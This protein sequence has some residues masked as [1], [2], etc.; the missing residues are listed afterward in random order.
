MNK[1][2]IVSWSVLALI[3]S[4]GHGPIG[5]SQASQGTPA[6]APIRAYCI[7][8]NW[9]PGGPN[10]YPQPGHWAEADPQAHVAWYK[11]I[12]CNVIQTFCVSCNGYAWYKGGVVPEQP[13][14]KHDFL[15][16]VVRLGHREKMLV[17]GY[18][19]IGSNT[20][21]GRQHPELSY[22]SPSACHIPYTREYL[23]YLAAAIRDAV[24]KT[25]IDGFMIDWVWMPD[26]GAN[27]GK[28]LPCEQKLYR[29]LMGEEF[30]GEGRLSKQQDTAYSRKAIDRCWATIRKAA[31]EANPN[32]IIWLSCFDPTHPHVVDSRMFKEVDWLMNEGGDLQRIRSIR[33]MIG[34]HTRLIT[35]LADW[36]KQDPE[37]IVPEALKAGIGLYGFTKPQEDSLLPPLDTYL[38]QPPGQLKGDAKNIVVLARA[39]RAA[40]VQG[41]TETSTARKPALSA[42][43]LAGK[44]IMVLGDSITQGGSYV[45]F[46]EYYLDKRYPDEKFDLVSIGLASETLSG[47]SEPG[48]PFP[49]PCVHER[50]ERALAKVKPQVLIACYGMNDGIYHPQ[51]AERMKA[52]QDGVLRMIR[53]AREHGVQRVVLL[54]PPVFDVTAYVQVMKDGDEWHYFRPYVRYDDV[55][56][57]YA[58]WIM[59]LRMDGVT[60]VD[61]HAEMSA[62]LAERR[63]A[64]PN[65]RLAGDGIHPGDLGHLIMAQAVL[66]GL[67]EKLPDSKPEDELQASLDDPLYAVVYQRRK[68]RSDGWLPYVGY[69]RGGTFHR[70]SIDDTEKAAGKLQQKIDLLRCRRHGTD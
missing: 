18:F 65:Y 7:D 50:L 12:G 56:A 53:T 39:Y 1:P 2:R 64:N 48:H 4:L 8:F 24:K 13:G 35:C 59:S 3:G 67:G 6:V 63:K 16:E 69:T 19:C 41:G 60:T 15:S 68:L 21:W 29:E 28:W 36:N 43:D 38:K 9:G 25:G 70:D 23:D 46:L 54:T 66:K 33:P 5:V 17:M 30:P 47:L 20:R 58:R 49:R 27:G 57:D 26:R 51:S 32:C 52:F 10:G 40:A 44:R 34:S 61:V 42:K 14:L 11:G 55:L 37:K 31:K 45:S 22:N 62:A